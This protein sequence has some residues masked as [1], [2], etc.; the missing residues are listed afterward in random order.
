MPGENPV[1][2]LKEIQ[3]DTQTI[4]QF[5][6][7]HFEEG[8]TTI[9]CSYVSKPIYV[10]GG[11]VNIYPTTYLVA[12]GQTLQML[13]ADNVPMAPSMHFFKKAGEL[14]HFSLIFP[15]IPDD[16]SSFDFVEVTA[17]PNGFVVRNIQR[18][19]SGIYRISLA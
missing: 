8:Q 11:W 1:K 7:Q 12:N 2:K 4:Q 10:N 17:S 3:I 13:H 5:N 6:E 19:A 18:S 16:W 9:H 15:R 14:K